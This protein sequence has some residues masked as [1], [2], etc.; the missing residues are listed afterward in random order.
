MKL[1]TR[2]GHRVQSGGHVIRQPLRLHPALAGPTAAGRMRAQGALSRSRVSVAPTCA[3]GEA[4]S[5]VT[6]V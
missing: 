5:G 1:A 3:A 2:S 4:S 6:I